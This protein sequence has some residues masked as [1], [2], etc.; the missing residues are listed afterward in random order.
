MRDASPLAEC[1]REIGGTPLVL[2]FGRRD[3]P[4]PWRVTYAQLF[5]LVN[6]AAVA[7]DGN[8]QRFQ[9]R[10]AADAARFRSTSI[11]KTVVHRLEERAGHLLPTLAAAAGQ[12]QTVVVVDTGMQ[13]TLALFVARWF[14]AALELSPLSI[15]VRLVAVYPWLSSVFRGSHVSTDSRVV[16]ALEEGVRS[17]ASPL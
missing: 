17:G 7:A 12:R 16:E 15:G 14:E 13:G 1:Y 6:R 4:Q 9:R 3:L 10:Y 5:G 8:R 11:G 2:S